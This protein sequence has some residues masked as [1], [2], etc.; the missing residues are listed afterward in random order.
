MSYVLQFNGGTQR[1]LVNYLQN[2]PLE[3]N[4]ETLQFNWRLR[5]SAANVIWVIRLDVLKLS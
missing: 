1:E 4:F 3:I 2:P 5:V